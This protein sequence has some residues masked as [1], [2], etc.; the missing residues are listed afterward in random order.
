MD[1]RRFVSALASGLAMMGSVAEGQP[2]AKVYRVGFLLGA[3]AESVEPLFQSLKQ[4]L[5]DLGYVEGR[6]LVIERRQANGV[7]ERLPE[8]AAELVRLQVDVIVTG[9]NFHVAAVRGA[10]KTIPIVMVFV[11]DPVSAGFVA[12]LAHPGGNATGLSAEASSELWGKYLAM[13]K[14]IVPRLS[15]V[16]VIGQVASKVGFAELAV[17]SRKLRVALEVGD[18]KNPADLDGAFAAMVG[19]RVEAVL[20]VIGPL[21][22]LL[23]ERIADMALQHHLPTLS[24]A[25]QYAEA[26]LL[27]SY[28]PDLLD[29]YRRA[30]SYV[31]KILR[32][33]S[34]AD[35]PVE[36]PSKFELVINLKTAKVLG[37]TLPQSM[38][39]R[40][41]DVIE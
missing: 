22:Y 28:G 16:G 25:K 2:A 14:E 31:D 38:L 30:A 7:M 40:A 11:E 10:T 35:L 41:S 39:L 36:Q 27:M 33:A 8:L 29:L 5:R 9:T 19:K 24:N 3:T 34:P 4:G 20:V 17:A 13:M 32:G 6:N 26:G 21:T 23:K 1:R 12:S 18:L 15:H 37:V